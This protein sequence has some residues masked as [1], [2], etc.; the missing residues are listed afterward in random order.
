MAILYVWSGATGAADGTSWTDAWTTLGAA[1]SAWT[2]GDVC[3][4]HSGHAETS[5]TELLYAADAMGPGDPFVCYSVD[6]DN[7]DAYTPGTSAQVKVTGANVD[8]DFDDSAAFYG[9]W[10]EMVDGDIDIST[11]AQVFMFEDC[12]FNH[13]APTAQR[14]LNAATPYSSFVFKNC[15]FDNQSG[16][17]GHIVNVAVGGH[18]YGC[19]FLGR[20]TGTF[21]S[22]STALWERGAIYQGCDFS[23]LTNISSFLVAS[24]GGVSVAINCN[25]PAGKAWS[26]VPGGSVKTNQAF[27]TAEDGAS[28][29]KN[30]IAEYW[31]FS[32]SVIADTAIYRTAG[33]TDEDGSTQLSH[34]MTPDPSLIVSW[35]ISGPPMRSYLSSTG[36]KTWTVYCVHDFTTAPNKDE[37]WLEL[38][39]LGTS[40]SVLASFGGGRS[41]FSTTAWTVGTEAWTGA[42]GKTKMELSVT[43]TVNKAGTYMVRVCLGKY[44]AAKA[45]WYCPLV[46]VT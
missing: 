15:T 33:W 10:F 35:P 31:G 11:S 9:V 39:Y 29:A 30:Y 44:Q 14:Q 18:F 43:G 17:Q 19:T 23:G 41:I 36:S 38:F 40:N 25:L 27:A 26:D 28:T 22:I 8:I 2:S 37:C 45:L 4:M 5:A 12:T 46:E 42:A 3:Y 16:T 1:W 7:S 20:S 24:G 32:G 13:T 6:K 21:V 34:K